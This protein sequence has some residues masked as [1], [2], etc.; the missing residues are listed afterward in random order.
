[1]VGVGPGVAL[2][3]RVLGAGHRLGR[4]ELVHYQG[5]AGADLYPRARPPATGILH[6]S[7]RVSSLAALAER[8]SVLGLRLTDHGVVRSVLGEWRTASLLTPA[9]LRLFALEGQA[10]S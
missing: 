6:A 2:D 5:A 3:I 8:A 7:F 10:S 4:V 9:G 1:M